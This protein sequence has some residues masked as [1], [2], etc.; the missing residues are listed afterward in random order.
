MIPVLTGIF[1]KNSGISMAA[2]VTGF[3]GA[4][5]IA[6]RFLLIESS[7]KACRLERAARQATFVFRVHS[8]F[9][10]HVDS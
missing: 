2:R 10:W 1:Y 7:L 9:T 5:L 6:L 4:R 8:L 3:G